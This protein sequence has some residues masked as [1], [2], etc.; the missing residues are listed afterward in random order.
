MRHLEGRWVEPAGCQVTGWVG[1]TFGWFRFMSSRWTLSC[2][3]LEVFLGGLMTISPWAAPSWY[4]PWH[5]WH[6]Q[7]LGG[8]EGEYGH[9]FISRF[10]TTAWTALFFVAVE[11]RISSSH[12]ILV[13]V[14]AGI[15]FFL[16][17]F[18]KG[19]STSGVFTSPG[20]KV[21]KLDL[22]QHRRQDGCDGMALL[23]VF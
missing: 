13:G 20:W 23:P 1:M 8:L 16:L 19:S 10:L 3:Q 9:I 18:E 15:S 2:L 17:S 11:L 21:K 14:Q 12:R 4:F 22:G 7:R 6:G 5:T